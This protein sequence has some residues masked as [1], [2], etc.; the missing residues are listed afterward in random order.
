MRTLRTL[1][2]SSDEGGTNVL[3]NGTRVHWSDGRSDT[4]IV[5]LGGRVERIDPDDIETHP[6]AA[7]IVELASVNPRPMTP[8]EEAAWERATRCA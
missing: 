4:V 7:A 8:A 3:E 6:L 1:T 5:H 2:H